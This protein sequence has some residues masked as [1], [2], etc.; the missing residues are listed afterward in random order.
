MRKSIGSMFTVS[1]NGFLLFVAV[2][3][4][5]TLGILGWRVEAQRRQASEGRQPTS[6]KTTPQTSGDTLGEKAETPTA[7][8]APLAV[9][10][11]QYNNQGTQGTNSQKFEA[12][13]ATFDNQA[14][15]DFV[16][17][18]GQVW[19]VNQVDVAGLYFN[20]AGPAASF[21]VTFYSNTAG[22]LPGTAVTNCSFTAASYTNVPAS[23]FTINL[24]TACVLTGGTYWVS[25][26]ANQN[27]TPAG[28]WA[29]L[30]RTVTSNNAAA[31]QNPGN[32]FGTPCATWGRRGAT[33]TID[34]PSPDQVFRLSG[35]SAA[36]CGYAVR[37][38]TNSTPT[39]IAD[40]AVTT[41][42]I[43]VSG[44]GTYLGAVGVTTFITHT[45]AADL[46]I[47]IMSPAGTVVTLTTDNGGSND[48]VFNG[49]RWSDK[50][51]PGGQVPYTANPNF[52]TEATYTNG[53]AMPRLIPEEPL[54]AFRGENPNGV[55][56]IT[57]SDDAAGDTG[58]LNSWSLELNTLATAPTLSG[59][60]TFTNS[61]ATP[62]ADVAVTTSTITVSGLGTSLEELTALTGITHTFNADL[63]ITLKSPAG[64]V[65]T[66]TTD[67]GG[68]NDDV[69][70]GT[71]W[72]DKANPAGQVP[73]T[74]N[75]GLITD[76]TFTNAVVATP[77]TPEESFGAFRGENPNGVW[78]LTISDD[79]AGDT[80]T[81]NNW[82]LNLRTS[83]CGATAAGVTVS[84]RVLGAG[85]RAL[86]NA[87]VSI[88]NPAGEAQTVV[89]GRNGQFTFN[90]VE[91][92]K[93][94]I[95]TVGSRRYIYQPQLIEVTDNV[96]DLLFTPDG[97]GRTG[98]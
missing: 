78:T 76:S 80:G 94:Y 16:V 3:S 68:S 33:C 89:T 54:D 28:Q 97:G 31:W 82:S 91:T 34:A 36:A 92:G 52:V 90:D 14:A 60:T 11:D 93:S 5:A 13:N 29:W 87:R 44:A 25:V 1:R 75:Q 67:N 32:G 72:N 48:D 64:T 12:A 24:P 50:V 57:I 66:L 38:V 88:L 62:I 37:T 27:F 43:T 7:P 6:N 47:T 98:R 70:N 58:T 46:D 61:T 35:T 23:N 9:L 19:N 18:A 79:A 39:P 8:D 71:L 26:Q 22:N 77:L 65:V 55:W 2:L 74:T 59:V 63:D 83:S 45:F 51:D 21:N 20:G 81:L 49:T 30:D 53:V 69:F 40:N 84:G 10:Y 4:L 56:T 42:T 73:Y 17:P 15:D 96:G 41:S 86:T 95:V 85:G